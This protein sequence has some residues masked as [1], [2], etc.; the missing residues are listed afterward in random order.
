MTTVAI[1]GSTFQFRDQIKAARD[2]MTRSAAYQW[3]GARKAWTRTYDVEV[4]EERAIS[5]IR[6][7]SGIGNR[8]S[9]AAEIIG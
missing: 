9:F 1:T 8:G 5:D 2:R 4:T 6:S 3:D 7:I